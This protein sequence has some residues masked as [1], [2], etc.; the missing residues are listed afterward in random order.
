[1]FF[2]RNYWLIVV[3]SSII[4]AI[5]GFGLGQTGFENIS[6]AYLAATVFATIVSTVYVIPM[7][8]NSMTLLFSKFV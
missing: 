5:G 7:L 6:Y 4:L 1:M 8:K 2:Y 3:N